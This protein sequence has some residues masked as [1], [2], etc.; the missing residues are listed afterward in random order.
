MTYLTSTLC[1]P[2]NTVAP[3][4]Q[5]N[6]EWLAANYD[7][8][9]T[10]FENHCAHR[11][12][13]MVEQRQDYT[14]FLTCPIHRWTYDQAGVLQG[15]NFSNKCLKSRATKTW[16]NF[17]FTEDF[18][19]I[20]LP[21][22]FDA[23]FNTD[24]Y[25]HTNTEVANLDSSWQ[26]FMEIYLDLYHVEPF[27]PGLGNFIDM[28]SYKWYFGNNWSLQECPI[29]TRLGQNPN[30]EFRRLENIVA[31][32]YPETTHGALWLAIYPNIML[33]W[34]PNTIVMSTIWP[35]A[36]TDT[37]VNVVEYFHSDEVV[38]FDPEF[39]EAQIAAY[40]NAAAEDAEAVRLITQGRKKG[41]EKY[42]W[43]P[44]LELGIEHFYKNVNEKA[45]EAAFS[46]S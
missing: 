16:N 23:M 35:G 37:S 20:V 25:V 13:R 34:Y 3:L 31:E 46:I 18:P 30:A 9:I 10:L 17:V 24:N 6:N 43:H 2:N 44:E 11:G 21:K 36:T 8:K 33:E 14:G 41:A 27:H 32:R 7:N 22:P 42:P 15:I 19:D 4:A 26:V 28:N 38:G 1:L 39:V 12:A 40:N 45:A 5:F 29:T